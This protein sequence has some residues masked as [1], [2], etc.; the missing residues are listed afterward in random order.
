M[1]DLPITLQHLR[2][3][4]ASLQPAWLRVSLAAGERA[5]GYSCAATAVEVLDAAGLIPY[6]IR[7]LGRQDRSLA[8]AR[9]SRFNCSYCRSCLQ[10]RLA[11][12]LDF[13]EGVVETNGCDHLRGMFE[14]WQADRPGAFFHYLKVP[15]LTHQEALDVYIEELGLFRAAAAAHVGREI[16]DQDLE[17]AVAR[18][19]RIR[20]QMK[21]VQALRRRETPALTGAESLALTLIETATEATEF[22]AMMAKLLPAL[23]AREVPPRRAR[24]FLGG[25]A[26]DELELVASLEEVG[27]LFVADGLCYGERAAHTPVPDAPVLERLARAYLEQLLCP[28]MFMDYERRLAHYLA[29]AREAGAHGA[30]LMHNKF[31]DLHGVDNVQ[32][33][34]DMEAAGLPVLLIEKEYG[35]AADMGR[36]QTRLQAFLERLGR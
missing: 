28:R 14:N 10:L 15:H 11:G 7:A 26:T 32:L 16:S 5:V 21:Q 29:A 13:L 24:L 30:V 6:R 2:E 1:S 23:R 31:C 25:S 22:E 33:Q 9:M 19:E 17:Q 4:A 8:D 18:R 35:A 36:L 3:Q 20:T 12:D 34:R 27:A